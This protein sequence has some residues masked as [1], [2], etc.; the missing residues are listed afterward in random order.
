[1]IEINHNKNNNC[2]AS[3][4]KND[5]NDKEKGLNNKET[6]IYFSFGKNLSTINENNNIS[7]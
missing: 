1:M 2:I 4:L 3:N 5:Q 6:K 7:R